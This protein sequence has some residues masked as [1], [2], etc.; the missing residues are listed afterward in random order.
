MPIQ[1]FRFLRCS[2]IPFP[3][4]RLTSALAGLGHTYLMVSLIVCVSIGYP[5]ESARGTPTADDILNALPLS[6]SQ[7]RQ[8]LNGNV[9]RWTTKESDDREI[10]VGIV[11]LMKANPEKAA[12]LFRGAEGY[13]LIDAVTA[14]GLIAGKGTTA[15]FANLVLEPNGEKET[16]RYLNAKPGS[17]LN[18]DSQEIAA[19]HALKA[20]TKNVEG[21]QQ[22]VEALIK[23]HFLARLQAYQAKGLDGVNPFKRR[24]NE[25]RLASKKIRLSVTANKIT[26]SLYPKFHEVLVNYPKADM[27]GV[28]ES[29]FWAEHRSL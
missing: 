20:K 16:S 11:M 23:K 8:V 3:L 17:A 18:L 14:H 22:V 28:E 27:T 10:A 19:F 25:K 26:A 21:K 2:F 1:G 4:P 29:F 5:I 7:K 15:D 9:V 13:K 12:Q 6:A 24:G